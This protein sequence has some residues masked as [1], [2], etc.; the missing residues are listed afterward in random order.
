[1]STTPSS[2]TDKTIETKL[3]ADYTWLT[4]HLIQLAIVG[5]LV[6]ASVWGVESIIARHDSAISSRY[7][8]L[9]AQSAAQNQTIQKQSADAIAQLATQNSLLQTQ[10]A[11]LA[12]AISSR[13]AALLNLQK[14]VINMQPPA[15]A[16]EWPKYIT[17]G[18]VSALPDGVKLDVPAAQDTLQQLEAV[19]VLQADNKS[20]SDANGKQAAEITNDAA[21]LK[22][23]QDALDTE[24]LSHVADQKA[25]EADKKTLKAQ[26]RKGKLKAFFMGV[27]TGLIGGKFI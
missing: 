22:S 26:A 2:L 16:A 15:L 14:Q 3:K 6:I 11:G 18:T 8:A 4:T 20:L 21:A 5:V 12:Q 13:D 17:H 1:M 25:C 7:D 24:K 27:V 9:A 23:S 10:V 19:P